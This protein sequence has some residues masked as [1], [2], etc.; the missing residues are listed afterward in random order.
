MSDYEEDFAD[1]KKYSKTQLAESSVAAYRAESSAPWTAS[2]GITE[3]IPPLFDGSTSWFKYEE[4]ID[5]WLDLTQMEA[6]LLPKMCP[7]GQTGQKLLNKLHGV[8]KSLIT[9]TI[10]SGIC[11]IGTAKIRCTVCTCQDN[12]TQ[13]LCLQHGKGESRI[14]VA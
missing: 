8:Q 5:E 11:G 13:V 7:R 10:W 6:G 9:S 3:K 4:L 2:N 12:A 14:A 1:F